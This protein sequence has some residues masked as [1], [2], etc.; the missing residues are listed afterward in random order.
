[1]EIKIIKLY[2]QNYHN[3]NDAYND[4]DDDGCKKEKN[5]ITINCNKKIDDDNDIASDNS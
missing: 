2:S 1:M 3:S 4:N 5:I